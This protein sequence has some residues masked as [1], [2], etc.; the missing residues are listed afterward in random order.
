L[1]SF[2][3]GIFKAIWYFGLFYIPGNYAMRIWRSLS[4]LCKEVY[5]L[6]SPFIFL[7]KI[8]L[9]FFVG[10]SYSGG[11]DRGCSG[12]GEV[13]SL[14]INNIENTFVVLETTSFCTE[15][16]CN[17]LDSSSTENLLLNLDF[18][19]TKRVLEVAQKLVLVSV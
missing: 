11:V 6:S 10:G 3:I 2:S 5:E 16:Y 18:C 19:S 1:S 17:F 14:E 13:S 15:N 4:F 8:S 12:I 7:A 9:W